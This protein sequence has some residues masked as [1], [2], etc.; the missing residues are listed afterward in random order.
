VVAGEGWHPGVVGIVASRLVERYGRP[1]LVAAVEGD[2]ARGSGRSIKGFDLH[3]GLSAC[4]QLLTRFGGHR[5]AAGFELAAEDV[6]ALRERFASHAAGVLT[7]WDLDPVQCVDAIASPHALG[8]SLAQE[9]GS[10][11]PF[12]PGNPTPTLLIPAAKLENVVPM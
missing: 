7:P 4:D 10:L 3:A 5:M 2:A 12:G 8:L 9:L 1:A 11:G 6:P